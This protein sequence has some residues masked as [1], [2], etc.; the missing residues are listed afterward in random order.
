MNGEFI[1]KIIISLSFLVSIICAV[2]GIWGK[3]HLLAIRAQVTSIWFAIMVIILFLML[4][5]IRLSNASD[6]LLE[7]TYSHYINEHVESGP[8]LKGSVAW[9]WF[10][11]WGSWQH[12]TRTEYCQQLGTVNLFG[13][14]IGVS[15]NISTSWRLGLNLGYYHPVLSLG[16]SSI[17]AMDLYLRHQVT[18]PVY[19]SYAHHLDGNIGGSVNLKYQ[20]GKWFLSAGYQYL[21]LHERITAYHD[22]GFVSFPRYIDYSSMT[23]GVGREF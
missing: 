14:G 19:N 8:G 22:T 7:P 17:E 23:F 3:T 20:R 18:G 5:S 6:F 9:D 10:N 11:V 2:Y 16:G 1:F 21:R 12:T 15:E 13:A 4:A